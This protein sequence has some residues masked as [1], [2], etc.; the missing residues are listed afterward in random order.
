MPTFNATILEDTTEMLLATRI[1]VVKIHPATTPY[2]ANLIVPATTQLSIQSIVHI[3]DFVLRITF[4]VPALDN[5]PLNDTETY[6]FAPPL[7]VTA[8]VPEAVGAPT[9]VD[10]TVSEQIEGATYTVTVNRVEAA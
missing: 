10:V 3:T 4:N 9:Y 5:A 6:T 7:T 2:E 8:V 1:A